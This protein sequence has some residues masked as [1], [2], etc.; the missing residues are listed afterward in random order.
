MIR[1]VFAAVLALAA[2]LPAQAEIAIQ[3]VTSPGG[4][5]AWLVEV[6][7][8]TE[9]QGG[10]IVA[11]ALGTY[12]AAEWRNFGATDPDID[13]VWWSSARCCRRRVCARSS[14]MHWHSSARPSTNRSGSS[15]SKR[16]RVSAR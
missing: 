4:I 15:T 12:Q 8:G 6:D 1:A 7:L 10:E 14:R 11:A 9:D 3:E 2:T 16:W 13:S 5:D